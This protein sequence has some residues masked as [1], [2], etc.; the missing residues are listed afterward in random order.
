ME[1]RIMN[2]KHTTIAFIRGSIVKTVIDA[3]AHI[4]PSDAAAI[5]AGK[6]CVW[7]AGS[8]QAAFLITVITTVI[9]VIT[10]VVVWH[11]PAIVTG[12]QGGLT[13]VKSCQS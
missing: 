6:L 3:I 11:T 9:V 12:I 13:G 8:K 7:V 1:L 2:H 5:V 10:A 4:L